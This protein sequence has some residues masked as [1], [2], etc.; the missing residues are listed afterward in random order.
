MKKGGQ[1]PQRLL[2]ASFDTR[3][4][5]V[6]ADAHE[7]D[8]FQLGECKQIARKCRRL[9]HAAES[10]KT[11]KAT[12]LPHY[13]EWAT[14]MIAVLCL[15]R[16]KLNIEG[17]DRDKQQRKTLDNWF[18]ITYRLFLRLKKQYPDDERI[19]LT[20]AEFL[21]RYGHTRLFDR[22]LQKCVLRNPRQVHLW[23][24]LVDRQRQ[25]G[26]IG[27]ALRLAQRAYRFHPEDLALRQTIVNLSLLVT[28]GA[29][30]T[31]PADLAAAQRSAE[32]EE[33]ESDD[34]IE[35]DN[36][37]SEEEEGEE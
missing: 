26:N 5:A 2:T 28:L 18:G 30:S 25:V 8:L 31:K 19:D 11:S 10:I 34:S 32:L 14:Y 3:V 4:K 24:L 21:L 15:I 16:K 12:A 9:E 1:L 6:L 22:Y 17:T 33:D 20:I 13:L 27:A 23:L 35:L 37:E 29:L 7:H 36:S